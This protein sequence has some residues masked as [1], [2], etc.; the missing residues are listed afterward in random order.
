MA[1]PGLVMWD[2]RTLPNAW[3][4]S[5]GRGAVES[6]CVYLC[7]K[8]S[9]CSCI[10]FTLTG[11]GGLCQLYEEATIVESPRPPPLPPPPSMPPPMPSPPVE[12]PPPPSP[13]LALPVPLPLG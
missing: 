13:M 8:E 12:A 2:A 4:E 5:E 7:S 1:C 6:D 10:E 3:Y 9:R 11:D